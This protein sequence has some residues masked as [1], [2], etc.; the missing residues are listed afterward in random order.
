[1]PKAL[2]ERFVGARARAKGERKPVTILFADVV[3][4]TTL[5][6]KR[7]PEEVKVILEECLALMSAEVHRYEGIVANVMGDGLL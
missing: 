5:A 7:D 6:E 3:G 1:M 4:S 2:V